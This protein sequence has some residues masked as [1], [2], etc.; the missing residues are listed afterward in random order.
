MKLSPA[1]LLTRMKDGRLYREAYGEG[2]SLSRW[3]NDHST[4]EADDVARSGLDT[5]DHMVREANI[6]VRTNMHAGYYAS[7]FG[8]FD[9]DDNTRALV[10]EFVSRQWRAV[11]Y[12]HQRA[13]YASNDNPLNTLMNPYV[14]APGIRG[15]QL[16]PAI[17][18]AELVAQTT[19]IDSDAYRAYYLLNSDTPEDDL[20]LKRIGEGAEIPRVKLVGGE[21]SIRL[22]KF[23]RVLEVSYETLRRQRID[24]VTMHIQRMAVQA[25]KDKVAAVLHVL[26]N[27]DGNANT[28]PESFD[29]VGDL[30]SAAS[31]GTLSLKG[32]INFRMQFDNPYF[33]TTVLARDNVMLQMM[34]LNTGS[35][36]LPLAMLPA[37]AGN[38]GFTPINPGL[39]DGL[40]AGWTSDAPANQ[41]VAFDRRFAIERVVE[42]GSNITEVER[43]TTRQVQTLAMTEVE[44]YAV[45]DAGAT[46]ILN[47]AA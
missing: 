42:I 24:M 13:M 38:F 47:L 43:W 19:P 1:E 18:L 14:D 17:P 20:R 40:R 16:T 32:W 28:T 29:L 39:A 41:I 6:I 11:A 10:P 21:H 30:D 22:T 2:K 46:K 37:M 45:L 23:G 12:G 35:A 36:N 25:E 26:I 31:T 3:L 4:V 5:F 8:A 7:E 9:E 34:L 27:G 33:P 15:Q 44:G